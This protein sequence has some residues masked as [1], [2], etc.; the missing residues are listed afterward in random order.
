MSYKQKQTH[1]QKDQLNFWATIGQL[2]LSGFTYN[3]KLLHYNIPV[4]IIKVLHS[5]RLI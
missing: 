4:T 3:D 5:I 1:N 2:F